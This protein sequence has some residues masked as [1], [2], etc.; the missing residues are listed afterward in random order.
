MQTF[1]QSS[2]VEVNA[3]ET[4]PAD[5][6][7]LKRRIVEKPTTLAT[8]PSD[9]DK[10]KQF[11]TLDRKVLRFYAVWDDSASLFGEKRPYVRK[12]SISVVSWLSHCVFAWQTLHYFLVD[13]T[14][15]VREQHT[16]NDGRDKFPMLLRRQRVLRNHSDLPNEFPSIV[17][18][19]TA[20][21]NDD[22]LGP[23]DLMIGQ[24]VHVLGR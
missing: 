14:L 5:P 18:E 20:A 16:A 8:T 7:T 2:G 17:L 24:T 4:E 23:Q 22:Y 6:Y 9:F 13:D 15:E 12:G 3:F 11:V 19:S 21:E 1:L 10:L